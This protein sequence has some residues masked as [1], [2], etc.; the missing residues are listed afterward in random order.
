MFVG[1]RIW[2]MGPAAPVR[3][4]Q[5]R[6]TP[7]RWW[8]RCPPPVTELLRRCLDTEPGR[9]PRTLA[10]A[11]DALVAAH[12]EITGRSYARSSPKGGRETA[13][14]LNNRAV[15]LLDLG[16]LGADGLWAQALRAEPQHLE[17]SYNQAL[18]AWGH[19]KIG[20]EELLARVEEARRANAEVPRAAELVEQAKAAAI[21]AGGLAE[22]TRNLKAD[23]PLASWSRPTA[24]GC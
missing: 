17:S 15:S 4:E 18:H 12:P 20:D 13:D 7:A 21:G 2:K 6:E 23:A 14:S 16:R 10:E 19:G 8:F 24:R 11:A 5:A 9:R 3:P 1:G 22:A